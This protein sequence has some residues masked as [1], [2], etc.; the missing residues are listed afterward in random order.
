V[1][2]RLSKHLLSSPNFSTLQS[3]YRTFHSTETTLAKITNDIFRTIDSGSPSVLVALD[4]SSAFDCVSHE[5]LLH[6]LTDDFGVCN[7]AH[8]WLASNLSGR[9]YFVKVESG[10]SD[11]VFVNSGVPQGSRTIVVHDLYF[12]YPESY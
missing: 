1:H 10:I 4:F 9:T 7:V 8:A 12:T 5:K 2:C 3:A 6:R 11:T